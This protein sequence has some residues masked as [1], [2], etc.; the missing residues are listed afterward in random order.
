MTGRKLFLA[1]IFML[2]AWALVAETPSGGP[3][4]LRRF[5]FVA[6]SNDGGDTLVKLKYA[7]TDARSFAAVLQDLGGVKPRDLVLVSSSSL[8]RFEDGM[9]RVR[10]MVGSPREMD[11]RRELI[12]YYSGHSDDE[13]LILGRDRVTWEALRADLNGIGADVKVAIVDSCSSGSLTRA[14]GGQARP[15]FL[16]DASADMTGHAYLT[17]ASAEEAAQESDR[18]GSSFFTHYLISGLRGA[19]DTAGDGMVTL[20]EA[21]S[22]AFQET[23]ASTERTQYGPQHPAYDINLSGSGDLVLTDLRS[24][25]GILRVGDDISGRLYVRDSEGNLEVELNKAGGQPAELGLQPGVYSVVLDGK[26]SRMEGSVKLTSRQP[27]LLTLANLKP[28]PLDKTAARGAEPDTAARPAPARKSSDPAAAIGAAVGEIVGTAIGNAMDAAVTAAIAAA[29]VAGTHLPPASDAVPSDTQTDN[30]R[31]AAPADSAA[32]PA[33]D[34]GADSSAGLAS[35]AG[36]D[37]TSGSASGSAPGSSPRS[38]DRGFGRHPA[39]E[40]LSLSFFPDFSRGLFGSNRDHILA[41]NLLAGTSGSSYAFEVGGLANFESGEVIGFQVAGLVNA[42][43]GSVTGYQSAGLFN[44]AAGE[45]RFFQSA[46]LVNLDGGLVGGQTAGIANVVLGSA[47][48]GQV[49]GIGNW[50]GGEVIGAQIAGVGNWASDGISGAQ[51]SGVFNWGRSVRGPQIS[52]VNIADSVAGVQIGVVNIAG[53]VSGVQVGVLNISRE[54][55][56]VPVGVL[57]IEAR[58]RHALDLWV[59]TDGVPYAALSLGTRY[60]Y[61]VLSAGWSPGSSPT[62]WSLGLGLGGRAQIGRAFLDLDL[63]MVTE[64]QGTTGWDSSPLGLMYPR[65]RLVAGYPLSDWLALTAGVSVRALVPALSDS[66]PGA[67][68][69][70]TIFQPSFIVGVHLG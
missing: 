47:I 12:F 57:S 39:P 49:A 10:Q 9:Q 62:L 13:G 16:F 52:V 32:G 69:R 36:A 65:A 40:V 29:G 56:G 21:Y 19:A 61:T 51:V 66:I 37:S 63:S 34:S 38:G 48:G 60:L 28:V 25:S 11:E 53:H 20:N 42:S 3:V 45:A 67:D 14:K 55:D 68:P 7:E 54:I 23:L 5:A 30:R 22:Y 50:A 26:S 17:S 27:A 41:V 24:S 6:G 46:G 58:G 18:I 1:V 44:Y 35:E 31:D 59:D 43:L 8:V 64:R 15:A 70:T 33:A 4:P 2:A